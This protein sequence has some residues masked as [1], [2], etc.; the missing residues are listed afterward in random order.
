[1]LH[2]FFGYLIKN[3][4]IF[5]LFIL[6]SLWVFVQVRDIIISLFISYIIMSGVLPAVEYLRKKRV[7]RVLSVLIPYVSIMLLLMLIIL[8]LIP[9]AVSQIDSLITGFPQILN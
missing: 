9:F 3:Q 6:A 5:A 1:M 7:P 8:P 2:K 4:V